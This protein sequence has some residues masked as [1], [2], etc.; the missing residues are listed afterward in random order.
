MV[1]GTKS[2]G[3]LPGMNTAKDCDKPLGFEAVKT[4]VADKLHEYAQ[5]LSKTAA[6]HAECGLAQQGTR[7]GV[8]LEKSAE[9]VRQF[10]YD[11]T[12]A[13]IREAVKRRPGRS[14]LIAGA[15]GLALGALFRRR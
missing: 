14:L 15:V 9:C 13:E 2:V 1:E 4:A 12:S 5:A 6:E 7:A 3:D 8:W 11:R 10:D